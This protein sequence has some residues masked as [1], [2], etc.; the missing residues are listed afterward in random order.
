MRGATAAPAAPDP[1]AAGVDARTELQ[2]Q[3]AA[4]T[5]SIEAFSRA[6]RQLER[7]AHG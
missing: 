2:A 1:A 4:G 5:I 6:W 3:L 7:P